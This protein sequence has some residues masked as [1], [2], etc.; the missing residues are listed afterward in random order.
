MRIKSLKLLNFRNYKELNLDF[1]EGINIFI[2]EN[3]VGKTNILEA[4]YVLSLTKSNRYGTNL[5]LIN[6]QEES[7][8]LIGEV[9]YLDYL[10]R[11]QVDISKNSKK[12]YINNQE[13]K[14][15]TDY[16]SNFCVTTF[17]PSDIDIIKGSPIVLI[18]SVSTQSINLE[19]N[20]S[21][22]EIGPL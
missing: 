8:S 17:M 14:R 3:G 9:D 20:T 1:S 6:H 21:K 11:Y 5:D 16:I 7:T 10:K 19:S 12:V 13:I 15:I 18:S 4:I 22:S 2:G